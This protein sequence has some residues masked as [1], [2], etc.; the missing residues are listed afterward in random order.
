MNDMKN[1][2]FDD[3]MSPEDLNAMLDQIYYANTGKDTEA[4]INQP[5]PRI[6]EVSEVKAD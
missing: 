3:N 5:K 6:G 1:F 4:E 2:I